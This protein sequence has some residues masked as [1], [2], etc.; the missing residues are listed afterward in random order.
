MIMFK[1]NQAFSSF[2]VRDL[3]A[4][5]E[6]YTNELGLDVSEGDMGLNLNLVGRN[7]IF[8]YQKDNHIPATYTILNFVVNDIDQAVDELVGHGVVF[9]HYDDLPFP[10]DQDDKGILRGKAA[11]QGPDIAWLKDP[12]GNILSILSN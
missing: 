11:H 7:P 9:E 3:D 2:S 6:F 5:R 1:D 4:A 8:M 12:S 10:Q